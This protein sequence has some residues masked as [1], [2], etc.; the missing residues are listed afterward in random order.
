MRGP[1]HLSQGVTSSEAVRQR[2]CGSQDPMGG[3]GRPSGLLEEMVRGRMAAAGHTSQHHFPRCLAPALCAHLTPSS[4]LLSTG[5]TSTGRCPRTSHSRRTPGP[6]VSSLL[7]SVA[8]DPL[9]TLRTCARPPSAEMLGQGGKTERQE[10][11]RNDGHLAG[12]CL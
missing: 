5:L 4:P 9:P 3:R 1:G 2:R 8:P 7:L 10:E 12:P 6:S 11:G